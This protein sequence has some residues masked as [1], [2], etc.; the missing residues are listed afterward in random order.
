MGVHLAPYSQ[1]HPPPFCL[2]PNS[3]QGM[4][5]GPGSK[6][7]L[8]SSGIPGGL[9]ALGPTGPPA[10]VD[11]SAPWPREALAGG[12]GP[13][14]GAGLVSSALAGLAA[15]EEGRERVL[16]LGPCDGRSSPP[17][18]SLGLTC[19]LGLYSALLLLLTECPQLPRGIWGIWGAK[20]QPK[21]G[22]CRTPSPQL[23]HRAYLRNAPASGHRP[24]LREETGPQM[25]RKR[26]RENHKDRQKKSLNKHKGGM[27]KLVTAHEGGWWGVASRACSPFWPSCLRAGGDLGQAPSRG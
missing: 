25:Q 10:T 22:P 17:Y 24:G 15:G 23:E 26:K 7:H 4:G 8:V 20:G 12:A 16:R 3:G 2:L 13:L 27:R 21:A 14:T 1:P 5:S 18:P 6:A 11:G 9:G 19:L